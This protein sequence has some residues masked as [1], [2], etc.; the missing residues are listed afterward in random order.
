MR[1]STK[2]QG[3]CYALSP[4][5]R[6]AMKLTTA[7]I[8]FA[9]LQVSART[10]GQVT[11]S[12]KNVP[13][14]TAFAEIKKQTGYAIF[15]NYSFLEKAKPITVT[16][17]N[18][19]IDEAM[20]QVLKEQA[21]KYTIEGKTIV[22]E[23]K[24]TTNPP[25]T[26]N[27]APPATVD[28]HGVVKDEAGKPAAGVSVSVKG[29]NKGTTTNDNGEFTLIDIDPSATLVFSS[30]NMETYE[31]KLNGRNDLALVLKAKVSKLE[32]VEI[33]S[34]NT[35]YQTIPKERATGSFVHIDNALLNRSVSTN[36]LD[37]IN[38][39]TS[40][41]LFTPGLTPGT[42]SSDNRAAISIR[43]RSTIY[44]NPNPL[45]ILDNF[46]YDGDLST[47]NP[48]DI[49]SIDILKDAAAA[50]IWGAYSG[51]G[52]IVIT[53]KKGKYNQPMR[54]SLNTNFSI[55]NK[56]NLYYTPFLNT[57]DYIDVEQYLFGVG[58]FN[59]YTGSTA[60]ATQISPVG[61]ILIRQ[62]N[63]L[64]GA[65][66]ASAQISSLRTV[67]YRKDLNNYF[68]QPAVNQQYAI[69]LNGGGTNNQYFFSAGFDNNQ[70]NL[71]YNNYQRFTLNGNNTYSLF[72]DKFQINAGILYAQS[73]TSNNNSGFFNAI[74][75]W[76]LVSSDGL[77]IPVGVKYRQG[78][79]DTAG[80]GKLLDWNYRPLEEAQLSD[81]TI[82]LIN[83]TINL[84]LKYKI[85]KGFELNMLYQYSDGNS[86][87]QNYHSQTT[88]YARDLINR[89]TN[90]NFTTGT[91][92]YR[93][94]KGGIVDFSSLS[95]YSHQLR[96]VL[97]YSHNWGTSHSL[98][99]LAGGEIKNY[100]SQSRTYTLYG[101]DKSIQ[102]AANIDFIDPFPL[103][104]TLLGSTKLIP[105]NVSNLGATN[106]YLSY[107]ANLAYT[108]LGRYIIT[109][110]GR[111]DAS[112]I[113]GVSTN[114]KTVPLW[115]VGIKWN[116]DKEPFY[117][118]QWLSHLNARV[119]YG[120][121][122]N[123]NTNV[124]ALTTA[125]YSSN[126]NQWNQRVATLQNPPNPLLRWEKINILNIGLD[127]GIK[128]D[129]IKGSVEYY[130]KKGTDILGNAPI[131][132]QLGTTQ[133]FGNL[134]DTRGQG[135]DVTITSQIISRKQF[136]W[137]AEFLL[138][139]TTDKITSYKFKPSTINTYVSNQTGG[140]NP[141][142][143]NP[144]YAVMGYRF[145]GLDTSGRPQFLFDGKIS[146]DYS[147]LVSSTNYDNLKYIG[148]A[149]PVYFGSLRNTFAFKQISLSFNITYKMGYWFTNP[150][151]TTAGSGGTGAGQ[152][153]QDYQSRWQ[154]KGD[155][156]FTSIPAY[157]YGTSDGRY[158]V[159]SFSDANAIKGDHIR[160]QDLE[161]D[162]TLNKKQFSKLPFTNVKLYFYVNNIGILWRANNKGI[163]PDYT[164]MG[165]FPNPK[166]Y[167]L[168][169]KID[170]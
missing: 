107:F 119:T 76:Q 33:T 156:Q 150:Y 72:K 9:F 31:T 124:S 60:T 44:S 27:G 28:V 95:Y 142:E 82:K 23:A 114:E 12:A 128:G 93:I 160:L 10:M 145:A 92:T 122:A 65:A 131:A 16:L 63:G 43:G 121:N 26:I 51:N 116:L 140:V 8:L 21:L 4:Q 30:V 54:V 58:G 159:Y 11:Y 68:Y 7:F 66:D 106:R 25:A 139:Y 115:S 55:G 169:M 111:Q 42:V 45:I 79:L 102:T 101:Y 129:I 146:T 134:A 138:S 6:H 74:P 61:E 32:D 149:T 14:Q 109:V 113:F 157:V 166:T 120:Y 73:T 99:A 67:N 105:S 88:F 85:I 36:I 141:L 137:N 127:F 13:L 2:G 165:G 103:Y 20:Q 24:P 135:V 40:G 97:N 148:P 89:Y 130:K 29:T 170:F 35:G 49:E 143:G 59:F 84:G 154:K 164:V 108:Y 126:V 152:V 147:G 163:D 78:Y 91:I 75:E 100:N 80:Q 48:N 37:R 22:I 39:V 77:P 70:P 167:S 38:G 62:K 104:S 83:Y 46:P 94:P 117:N 136:Q 110:S 161:L 34:V 15:C 64:I 155:E 5:T 90:V 50:S 168:G 18:A 1:I 133:F 153:F 87:Q 98:T 158:V 69:N 86:T 112:N 47:I 17:K 125:T 123:S 53:T 81:N 151:V 96:T 19:S 144:V 71:K 162:Y 118:L 56:P 132:P 3:L 41:V 52:V 57:S